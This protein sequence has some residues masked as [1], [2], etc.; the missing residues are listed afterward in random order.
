MSH[1]E[2]HRGRRLII[3]LAFVMALTALPGIAGQTP[4]AEAA[5][6]TLDKYIQVTS[7]S[8]NSS[9]RIAV[10][11]KVKQTI[12]SGVTIQLGWYYP[13]AYRNSNMQDGTRITGGPRTS[14]YYMYPGTKVMKA[15]VEFKLTASTLTEK[16]RYYRMVTPATRTH[17]D[18]VSRTEAAANV[19]FP[20][21]L[22][23]SAKVAGGGWTLAGALVGG[24]Y[25][26][27]TLHKQV[28]PESTCPSVAAGQYRVTKSW[29]VSSGTTSV[30][31]R[32]RLQVYDNYS[33]YIAGIKACDVY[34]YG[35]TVS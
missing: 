15:R 4:R 10:T 11:Y 30:R 6:P 26:A 16:K 34:F 22:G 24:W 8:V 14:T 31:Q 18:Y 5:T 20:Y 2:R 25:V 21:V 29:W 9:G 1:S 32:F 23:T 13:N 35:M 19:L 28:W 33:H 12:P 3:L 17:V 7:V 27:D